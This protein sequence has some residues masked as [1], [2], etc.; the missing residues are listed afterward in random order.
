MGPKEWREVAKWYSEKKNIESQL[1]LI[2]GRWFYVDPYQGDNARVGTSID[3]ALAN[4]VTAYGKCVTGRGDGICVLSGGTTTANTTSYLTSALTWSKNNITV[5]GV[6]APTRFAQRARIAND[7]TDGL[8]LAHLIDVSG[9]DNRFYNI[10]MGN[11]GTTGTGCLRVTGERNYFGR[12]HL[13]G[14]GGVT[15]ASIADMDL[16][17]SGNENTFEDCVLGSD[18]F[19]KGNYA[20]FEVELAGNGARNRFYHC[21]FIAYRSAG[22]TAGMIK[23]TGGNAIVRHVLFDDCVFLMYRDGDG[24]TEVAIVIG[25]IPNNGFV[26]FRHC[27][28]VGFVDYG[29]SFTNRCYSDSVTPVE[30]SCS[31]V[32]TG[33]S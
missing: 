1:P 25:T 31:M 17:L 8:A 12:V 14:G 4:I 19:N 24:A 29:K 13:I 6:S 10:H 5:F 2:R 11:F 15:T 22:T 26:L 7:T 3:L 28:A 32:K 9:Y 18:T 27:S 30:S 23:L 21:E 20:G 16:Y 33:T